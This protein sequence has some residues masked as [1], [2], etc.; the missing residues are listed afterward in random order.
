VA[1]PKSYERQA[2]IIAAEQAFWTSGF[3]ATGIDDLEQATGLGRSSLYLAFGSKQGLFQAALTEYEGGFLSR[4][5]A[6]VE[7]PGAGLGEAARFFADLAAF[8]RDPASRRGCLMVNSI[9]ELAHR[10]AEFTP[11][12]TRLATRYHT[13]FSHALRGAVAQGDMDRGLLDRRAKLL[14]STAHGVWVLARADPEVAGA[15]CRAIAREIASWRSNGTAPPRKPA[16]RTARTGA[17]APKSATVSK[18]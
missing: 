8:F 9:T 12:A 3:L 7:A 18:P 2:V 16:G 6:G 14:A 10:D 1:R 4:M 15:T 5:L 11:V 17:Q 13:A